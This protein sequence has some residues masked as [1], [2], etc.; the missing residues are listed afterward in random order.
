MYEF[1]PYEALA[2]QHELPDPFLKPDGTRVASPEEWPAQREYLKAMLTHYL[3][4]EMPPDPGNVEGAVTSSES[5]MDGKAVH[6]TAHLS[7]GP[8]RCLTLDIEFWRPAAEVA[9]SLV[10]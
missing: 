7:F 1:L 6:E 9:S 8:D 2:E 10:T 3:Y 5:V 4:G